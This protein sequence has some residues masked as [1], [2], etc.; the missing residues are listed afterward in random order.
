VL[1]CDE[2]EKAH[3]DVH[4]I[5]LQLLDEGA[6]TDGQGR[7]V[8][9]ANCVVIMTS[10]IGSE[11]IMAAGSVTPQLKHELD[12][13]LLTHFR[14]EFI[15]RLDSIVYFNALTHDQVRR[16]VHLQVA[17]VVQRLLAQEI[18][19][20]VSETALSMLG[21]VGYTKEFGARPVRR[22]IAQYIVNPLALF[23][24]RNQ[25]VKEVWVD[26]VDGRWTIDTQN[27]LASKE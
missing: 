9:F 23:L 18:V 24:L 22:A 26:Y 13:Q 11:K 2:I 20:H 16:I 15:N 27:V 21:E 12:Q 6:L 19:L 7:R 25:G 8:S 10:N 5:F 17:Q 4:T 14:P 3:P 1:L